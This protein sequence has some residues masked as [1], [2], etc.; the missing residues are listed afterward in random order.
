MVAFRPP[1]PRPGPALGQLRPRQREHEQRVVS[2]PLEQVL[3]EVEQARVRPLQVLEDEHDG[4]RSASRSKKSRHAEK[5]SSRSGAVRSASPSRCASRGSSQLRAPRHRGRAPRSRR[6]ASRARARAPPPRRSRPASAPSRRAPSR[7]R[8]RR[9]RGSGRGATR[10]SRRARPCTSRTPR[11]GATCRSRRCPTTETRC[12]FPSSAQPWKSSLTMR[13]SRSRPTN[14]GSR[15]ADCCAPPRA[16]S[17][18]SARCSADRLRLPLQLVL[19][20]RLVGDRRLRRPLRRLADEHGARLRGR[21]DPRRRV[22]QVAGDHPLAHRTDRH[23]RL[24]GQY[25]RPG[26]ERRVSSGTAATRSSAARTARSASSSFATGV[27]HTAITAS[28][29][30]F[31]T[32]PP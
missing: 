24:A 16:A 1:A 11:R 30:N 9:R 17:T 4:P 31:S 3:D 8:P 25:P 32:V 12:A 28:P 27:P 15:P 13:S 22:H 21:L 14:G 20:R 2:R 5:R 23:R 7:R 10:P 29:M 19:A 6:G 18:R 26:R